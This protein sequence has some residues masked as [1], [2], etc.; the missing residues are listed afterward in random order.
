[1][2]GPWD[3]HGALPLPHSLP[4]KT[5]GTPLEGLGVGAEEQDRSLRRGAVDGAADHLL[6]IRIR[7]NRSWLMTPQPAEDAS[8]TRTP[9]ASMAAFSAGADAVMPPASLPESASARSLVAAMTVIF[10]ASGPMR[11]TAEVNTSMSMSGAANTT[12]PIRCT[13]GVGCSAHKAGAGFRA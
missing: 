4:S 1:M 12:A 7:Q 2:G 11:C 6:H 3:K 10:R 9:S 8:T 13:R 5:G